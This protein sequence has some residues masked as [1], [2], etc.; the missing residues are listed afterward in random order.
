AD[1]VDGRYTL[2]SGSGAREKNGI[3]WINNQTG[4]A[5][6]VGADKFEAGIS[7]SV[8]V[9]VTAKDG[10]SF[11]TD[12]LNAPQ[13]TGS[14]NGELV[15]V[16]GQ[17]EYNAYLT[18]TFDALSEAPAAISTVDITNLDL[19]A[20]G[21]KPDYEATVEDSRVT[22][23]GSSG[24]REKNGIRWLES[25]SGD[26]LL[27]ASGVFEADVLYEVEFTLKAAAG[28]RFAE[29]LK[30]SVVGV[31]ALVTVKSES[32]AV[33]TLPF[34]ALEK[35]VIS[36]ATLTGV[37]NGKEDPTGTDA[38]KVKVSPEGIVVKQLNWVVDDA[39]AD[40]VV[41]EASIVLTAPAGSR[42]GENFK[43][44]VD[45]KAATVVSVED[46]EAVLSFGITRKAEPIVVSFVDV[47]ANAW[48]YQPVQWAVSGGITQGTAADTFSPDM[49]CSQAH[50][51]TFLWRAVGKPAP[52]IAS[53]Y[54]NAAVVETEYFYSA[55]VWAWEKGLIS[56]TA[57][58]PHA[59]C[60]RS[61]VV[62]YLWKLDGSPA[63]GNASFD[64][65]PASAAYA[66][67]VAWAV[68]NEVTAG[69][70]DTT[71]SPD[72]TC[73]RGQIVTFLWRYL[74]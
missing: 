11:H 25:E 12:L 65:V 57:L 15:D 36:S 31:P 37:D 69:T 9:G 59:P 68:A 18:L 29:D 1:I 47:A 22:L 43:A 62:S 19:P 72:A 44:T 6:R 27:V 35:N 73:T 39:A 26:A 30:V 7:Y 8:V 67:A 61:D 2:R 53:P 71:F 56:N 5:M 38:G 17:D 50:I 45:G 70:S 20:L 74:K 63:A 60:S 58:D 55:F 21:A 66:Q 24:L 42:F 14:I 32:E 3:T 54:S 40:T 10:Y 49:T 28:Q 64:D 46:G 23:S 51:L 48:Y 33:A 4:S 16:S 41:F 52:T 34:S 13:I